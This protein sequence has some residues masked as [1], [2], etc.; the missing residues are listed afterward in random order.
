MRDCGKMKATARLACG[1][2]VDTVVVVVVVGV[3]GVVGV[4][5][6]ADKLSGEVAAAA[7]VVAGVVGDVVLLPLAL[8]LFHRGSR[9][10]ELLPREY[11][12][13]CNHEALRTLRG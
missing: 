6:V 7:A 1:V 11:K 8:V 3:V 4:V 2:T 9:P 12:E 10:G 13:R 5:V